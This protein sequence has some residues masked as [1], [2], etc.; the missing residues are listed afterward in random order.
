ASTA[1]QTYGLTYDQVVQAVMMGIVRGIRDRHGDARQPGGHR[2]QP[3][4]DQV[5]PQRFWAFKGHAAKEFGLTRNQIDTAIALGMVRFKKVKNPNYRSGPEATL[6]AI[7]D[8]EA[9]LD[10]IRSFSQYSKKELAARH[11][12]NVRRRLRERLAFRCPRC[13]KKVYPLDSYV[14]EG[15]LMGDVDY[16]RA[17]EDLAIQHY[18]HV[19]TDY[20]KDHQDVDKWLRPEE[21][22]E[23]TKGKFQSFKS[24]IEWYEG[25]R[26]GMIRSERK[27]L[28]R[29][30]DEMRHLAAER[31][32]HH[33]VKVAAKLAIADG[34]IDPI[35][36][37]TEEDGA[38]RST[39][40]RS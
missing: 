4:Q 19:Y 7:P 29:I 20:E 27:A 25:R 13:G 9:N 31:A 28:G 40:M 21:V 24:L 10:R 39:D 2:G 23:A 35:R 36:V 26:S 17:R 15:I 32:E 16:G 30:I 22:Y 18:F 38:S 14:F 34:L 37:G 11:R 3:R 33:Y 8:I 12:H 1:A 6:V 5:L